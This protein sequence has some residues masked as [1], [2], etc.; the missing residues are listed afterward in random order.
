MEIWVVG[1][2]NDE[3]GFEIVDAWA[4]EEQAKARVKEIKEERA[5]SD[6]WAKDLTYAMCI[7]N[8]KDGI[9]LNNA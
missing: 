4:T 6:Y 2:I 3:D 1:R 8:E 7:V 5:S 9:I